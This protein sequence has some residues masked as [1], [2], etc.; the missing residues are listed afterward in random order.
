M[1]TP[2]AHEPAT[3]YLQ[4]GEIHFYTI[5]AKVITVLGSCISII[6]YNENRR[7]G[8]I[9][10]AVMPS[11]TH[12][13]KC[14]RPVKNIFQYV[15]SSVEWMISRF[16]EYGIPKINIEVKIFGGAE[17]FSTGEA[18]K[19]DFAVGRKNVEAAL[20]II[21]QKQLKLKAWNIGGNKGRRLVF[22]T[23]TGDVITK[24]INKLSPF[25][26]IKRRVQNTEI[27]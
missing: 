20:G 4:P 14:H 7:I 1:R 6:M 23:D 24:Y 18:G 19:N 2:K 21:E 5:P 13:K 16:N 9:C 10:H 12:A 3:F 26:G 22:Y 8:S 25:D 27:K 15:D 11:L 17:I